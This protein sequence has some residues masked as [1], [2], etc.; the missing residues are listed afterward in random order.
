MAAAVL[1]IREKSRKMRKGWNGQGKVRQFE[2]ERGKSGK[3]QGILTVFHN[4]RVL[5]L[6]RFNLMISVSGK[7]LYQEVMKN[8]LRSGRNRGKVREMNVEKRDRPETA[9]SHVK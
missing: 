2:K 8:F 5:P 4:V 9:T 3:S 7:M 1:E 6:L